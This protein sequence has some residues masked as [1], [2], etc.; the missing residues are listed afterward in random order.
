MPYP[1]LP[2]GA[3]RLML[4]LGRMRKAQGLSQAPEEEQQ[5]SSF[6]KDIAGTASPEEAFISSLGLLTR[7]IRREW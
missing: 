5:L 2:V 1:A 3:A 7:L 4:P 6:K